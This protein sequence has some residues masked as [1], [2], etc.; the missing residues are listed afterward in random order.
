MTT[1]DKT[2]RVS[3][4]PRGFGFVETTTGE[5]YFIAPTLMKRLLPQDEITFAVEPGRQP[6]EFQ[7]GSLK[8]LRREPRTLLGQLE[9]QSSPPR[10]VPDEPCFVPITVP[11]AT[12]VPAGHVVA[13]SL[14]AASQA[15]RE[16]RAELLEVLGPRDRKGFD[17][18]YALFKYDLPRE[19]AADA[20]QEALDADR[21]VLGRLAQGWADLRSLPL[22]TIDGESTRDI[23]DAVAARRVRSGFEVEVA[24]A[25][26]S[27]Y[28]RPGSALE[29]EAL[30]RCTS[31]Y[32]PGRTV[33]MLPEALSSDLGSLKC[34]V[35][36]LA[37][38]CRMQVDGAGVLRSARFQRG[39]IVSRARLTYHQVHARMSEARPVSEDVAVEQSLDALQALYAILAKDRVA[40][41]V[42]EF[43][44]S[45]PKLGTRPDGAPAIT[46]E[47]RNDAHRLIEEIMLLANRAAADKLLRRKAP[48]FYRHQAHPDQRDWDELRQW[49]APLGVDLPA[50][51]TLKALSG[52][53]DAVAAREDGAVIEA[54]ARRVM[55]LAIYDNVSPEH[56]CLGF[57]AYTHFTSPLRRYSDLVVHRM[58]LGER[59][60]PKDLAHA[61]QRCSRKARDAKAAERYVWDRLKR[62]IL[63]RDVPRD[64]A[65]ACQVL[66]ASRRGL[67]VLFTQWQCTGFIP[68]D[69][70]AEAGLH[71]EEESG[72]WHNGRRV[73]VGMA[74]LGLWTSL[75]EDKGSCELLAALATLSG[76]H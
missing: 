7:V 8:S 2:G 16:L 17:A 11:G 56:F 9:S 40:R 1:Q 13:I 35:P 74:V 44:E 68:Q 18:D 29:R 69:A 43:N 32:L 75:T 38:V 58:L 12:R 65:L 72:A 66:G 59:Q 49:L 46:W 28:V 54:R 30:S 22:V 5:S 15:T 57:E 10:F 45:E 25:D 34:D 41:G 50:E 71:W 21:D 3:A 31:V 47:A 73:E 62:R 53:L 20:M 55:N 51:P 48:G 14:P 36:R 61:A 64:Q 63:V 23:D 26:V 60:R 6:G 76:S 42:I 19:H 24:I 70:L 67:K 52:M 39:V 37:L 33:P 27:A 4:H